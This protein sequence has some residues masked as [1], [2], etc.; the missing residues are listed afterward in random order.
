MATTTVY[1]FGAFIEPTPTGNADI[2]EFGDF[3]LNEA[4][5]STISLDSSFRPQSLYQS[6]D[7]HPW[8]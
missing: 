7:Y 5:E 8:F 3:F 6:W 2:A 1:E 4:E